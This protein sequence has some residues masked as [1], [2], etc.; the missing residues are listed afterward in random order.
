M[1]PLE[2]LPPEVSLRVLEFLG[3]V[4]LC[5]CL[6]VSSRWRQLADLDRLWK[7]FCQQRQLVQLSSSGEQNAT[8]LL[9]FTVEV[10]GH[11]RVL[12]LLGVAPPQ[13]TTYKLE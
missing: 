8:Q 4:D 2:V 10:S 12:G 13:N 1:D 7:P 6:A 11:I 5:R 9:D 3:A